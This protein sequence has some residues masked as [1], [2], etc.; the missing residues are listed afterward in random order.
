[1]RAPLVIVASAV[2]MGLALAAPAASSAKECGDGACGA[3]ACWEAKVRVRPDLARTVMVTCRNI[4][5]ASVL[6][7][8]AHGEVSN[9]RAD[10][11]T[12]QFDVRQQ[13]DAPRFDEAVLELTGYNGSVVEQRV[14]IETLPTSEN[15]APVCSGDRIS[16]RS[17][18]TGPVEVYM[19]PYCY[20]PDGDE[21]VIRGGPPGVHVE[22]PKSVAAGYGDSNWTY[23][24][25]TFSGVEKTTIWAT[26]VLGARSADAE[27]EISVGPGID[28]PPECMP[29]SWSSADDVRPIYSRPGATRRFGLYCTDADSDP[30]TTRLSSPPERGVLAAFDAGETQFGYFGAERWIDATYVP[31]DASLEP[32]PFSVTASGAG[33]DGPVARMAITPRELPENAG[34]HCGWWGAEVTKDVPST[35]RLACGDDDGDP[36]SVEVL[37]EPQHGA[38]TPPVVTIGRFGDSEI[39][40]P[41]VPEPGYEGYDCLKVKVTDGNGLDFTI[42]FDIWVR[43]VQAP[44]FAP[45][46]L[47]PVVP[48]LPVIPDGGPRALRA[49]VER[50]LGTTAVKRLRTTGGAQVW[51][52]TELSRHDLL[53]W[54]RAPGLVVVCSARC[55]I[56]ADSKLAT[57]V[58]TVRASRRRRVVA[59][60]VS[61]QPQV[62]SLAIGRS[63]RRALR[64]A[65]RPRAKFTVSIRPA[66]GRAKSLSRSI[67]VSR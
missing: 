39:T 20:D 14:S 47:P 34:G 25:A 2:A 9:P 23:R 28:R 11:G 63:E 60:A 40:I 58:R 57:G 53:R 6:T 45:P 59:A 15:Q 48:P 33:G 51:A 65:R 31:A 32:D 67:G 24:T 19:H 36:L 22:S 44:E 21:M 16:K 27:L 41:Y 1:M 54:G 38:I 26:D 35:L 64:R 50:A 4:S 66:G 37:T 42:P 62:L 43:P 18:G 49:A 30:F 8:P 10:Y 17:D 5:S 55:Q 52:R 61:G 13:A 56:R 3:P 29:S 7:Q 12:L 46:P